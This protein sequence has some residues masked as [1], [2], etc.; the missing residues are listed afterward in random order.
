MYIVSHSA[1]IDPVS[2]LLL[3]LKP[4]SYKV[5]F[6][7]DSGRVP[8]QLLRDKSSFLNP[9]IRDHDSGRLPDSLLSFALTFFK[10][11]ALDQTA[12]RVPAN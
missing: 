4:P 5:K 12:G 3:M 6:F 2:V 11:A 9:L 8:L 7:H 1:G 10:V